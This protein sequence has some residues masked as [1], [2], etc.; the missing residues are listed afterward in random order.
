MKMSYDLPGLGIA[1][2][3]LIYFRVPTLERDYPEAALDERTYPVQYMTT[4]E[5]LLDIDIRLPEGYRLKWAPDPVAGKTPGLEYRLE[6]RYDK[7]T[8][9]LKFHEEFRRLQRVIPVADYPAYR[10]ALREIA[11]FSQQE[12]FITREK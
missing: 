6:Y 5:R 2:K 7:K 8:R 10:D 3:D 9:A 12:V 1:A 11:R 4:E